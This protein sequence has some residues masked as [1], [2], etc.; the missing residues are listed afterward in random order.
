MKIIKELCRQRG[1]E[2][3]GSEV[4]LPLNEAHEESVEPTSTSE[5]AA[6]LW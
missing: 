6:V 4:G 1:D 5:H 3:D 2:Y